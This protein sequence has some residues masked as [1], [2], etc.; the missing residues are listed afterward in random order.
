MT[1]ILIPVN[2][3]VTPI[4]KYYPFFLSKVAE[5]LKHTGV[6]VTLLQFSDL[7]SDQF[8]NSLV[9]NNQ[10]VE[11][12]N[13]TISELEK[14]F[15]FSFRQ[16]LYTDLMQTSQFVINSRYRNF[17]IPDK[18]F[19]NEEL[20]QNKLNQ[21][22]KILESKEYSYVITDQTTDF[23]H[24]FIK[25]FCRKRNIPFMRY[26]PNFMNRGYFTL[27][28][29]NGN[30][31]IMELPIDNYDKKTI[32]NFIENY[33]SKGNRT[34][35][36][37]YDDYSHFKSKKSLLEKMKDKK[38]NDYI[39]YFNWTLSD[40]YHNKIENILKKS[41]YS[42][43]DNTEKYIFYG[44]GL[45]TESHVALHSYPFINQVNLIESISRSLPYGYT[46]YTK[47]HPWFSS[48]IGLKDVKRISKLPSVKILDPKQSIRPILNSAKGVVTLN[49]TVGIEALAIGCPVVAL[50]EINSYTDFH[51]NAYFCNNA[52]D[53]SEMIVKMVNERAE[54]EDTITYFMKMF[55]HS[56]D[57]PFEA[58]R[59]LSE[60][61]ANDKAKI[62]SKY[63]ELIIK[64]YFKNN[65]LTAILK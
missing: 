8:D 43:F 10:K 26:L 15:N 28:K 5:E 9:I 50:G 53:L 7:L 38:I 20:Y 2:K 57:I 51:P 65:D 31:K 12:K 60:E 36:K 44:L 30:I 37:M 27:Y 22:L 32:I 52:Y 18:N 13:K 35:Y 16:I 3:N 62:F 63:I 19:A 48:T 25:Y 34:I 54:E 41:Y 42:K 56:S 1:N 64:K 24:S 6:N 23:E 4:Y 59:Y 40:F 17:F 47:P 33:K 55:N 45:A 29:P 39:N 49:G 11:G 14:E 58:D 46:L 21:I 61:D